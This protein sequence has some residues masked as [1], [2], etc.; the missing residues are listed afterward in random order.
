M[1]MNYI[2]LFSLCKTE[3]S[4]EPNIFVI[5]IVITNLGIQS[6]IVKSNGEK[7]NPEEFK[8]KLAE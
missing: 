2:I 5:T 7:E 3:A 8:E 1:Y 6:Y 4:G